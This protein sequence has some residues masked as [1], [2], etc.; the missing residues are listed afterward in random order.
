MKV[1]LNLLSR[2][3]NFLKSYN[4][5]EPGDAVKTDE[6]IARIETDKLT[7][8]ILAAFTGVIT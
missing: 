8:D 3:S 2:V 6:I 5:I 4:I 1:L 7:V